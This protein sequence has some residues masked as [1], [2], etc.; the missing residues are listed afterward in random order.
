MLHS[1][2]APV[3]DRCYMLAI[4]SCAEKIALVFLV[5]PSTRTANVLAAASQCSIQ[6]LFPQVY[7]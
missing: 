1:V 4:H 7:H 2:N 3:L 5:I 6:Y